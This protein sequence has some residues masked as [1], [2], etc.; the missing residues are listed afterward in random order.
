MLFAFFHS[1]NSFW[2]GRLQGG[3]WLSH[4]NIRGILTTPKESL[5]KWF[6]GKSPLFHIESITF[7]LITGGQEYFFSLS[8]QSSCVLEYSYSLSFFAF[9]SCFLNHSL[10]ILVIPVCPESSFQLLH[11]TTI[12]QSKEWS[13]SPLAHC[14][15]Q[16]TVFFPFLQLRVILAPV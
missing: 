3:T 6:F 8:L 13:N 12:L 5:L 10:T 14:A 11:M 9:N 1:N 2:K 16:R 4:G 7:S 15:K